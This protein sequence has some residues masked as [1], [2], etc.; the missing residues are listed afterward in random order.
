LLPTEPLDQ[1]SSLQHCTLST[2]DTPFRYINR[3]GN[4]YHTASQQKALSPASKVYYPDKDTETEPDNYHQPPDA[5]NICGHL[6]SWLAS[7]LQQKAQ[8]LGHG[9][10]V[11]QVHQPPTPP[12]PVPPPLPFIPPTPTRQ[13][14]QSRLIANTV[15][16]LTT[17]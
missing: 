1:K 4:K 16:S 8:T 11:L 12:P 9:H 10:N 2:H 17:A 15:Q 13:H 7:R 5:A 14:E 3:P 6:S